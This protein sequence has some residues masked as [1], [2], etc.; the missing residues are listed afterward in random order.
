MSP[1]LIEPERI[2]ADVVRKHLEKIEFSDTFNGLEHQR[3]L[4][5]YLV[6]QRIAGRQDQIKQSEIVFA[7]LLASASTPQKPELLFPDE[8]AVR[9]HM[10]RLRKS[11]LAYYKYDAPSEPF[12]IDIPKGKYVAL[13]SPASRTPA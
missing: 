7:K 9:T 10:S 12:Q 3:R 1:H 13:F 6:D 8:Q 4:V 11:L 2:E 5:R